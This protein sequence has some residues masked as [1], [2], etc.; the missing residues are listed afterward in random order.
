MDHT[1]FD[2]NVDAIFL[3]TILF[4]KNVAQIENKILL[5]PELI[6]QLMAY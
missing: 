5:R 4:V 6:A 1:Q 3:K 2:K